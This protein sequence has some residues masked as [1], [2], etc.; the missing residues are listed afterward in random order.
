[1]DGI[2]N[3]YKEKGFTSHDVVAKL[4]GILHQ[5]KIG[6]TGTLDPEA[7][8]V[9]PVCLGKA[10][11]VCGLLTDQDKSYRAVCQLGVETDTQDLTGQILR[12]SS[13]SLITREELEEC[14]AQFQGEL[15]QIPPMFSAVKVNGKRLYELAREGKTVE[16]K[17]RTVHIYSLELVD[18]DLQ[19]GC[20]TMDVTC[21]KG[22]YIRTLCHDIGQR[23]GCL[24]AMKSL[25]RTRVSVF[26]LEDALTLAQIE[27]R[28]RMGGQAFQ[29]ML[30][31]VDAL[32]PEY[33]A[34]QIK[35][36]FAAKLANGNPLLPRFLQEYPVRHRE[37]QP[38]RG[39]GR[40]GELSV[41]ESFLVYDERGNFKA[42]Y[43]KK[44][45]DLRVQK[46]F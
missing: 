2:I 42:V 30:L 17:P 21:S 32:F 20:F 13:Y 10:T 26:A 19:R 36:E 22:T 14:L 16:R 5:K 1:M 8:G 18:V 41:G 24:A 33:S 34:Y 38:G 43:Q 39:T 44:D 4:R 15:Q 11:R 35:E 12:E 25:V 27:E 9:L 40:L 46:M 23:L 28:V 6:H 37:E 7:V 29:E 31:S 3:V 45:R